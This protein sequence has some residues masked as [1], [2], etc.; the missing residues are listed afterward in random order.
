MSGIYEDSENK[1]IM[2]N[3]NV[4]DIPTGSTVIPLPS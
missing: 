1:D 3:V 4:S 2:K